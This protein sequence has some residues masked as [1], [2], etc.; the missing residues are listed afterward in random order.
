MSK[1][2]IFLSF[3]CLLTLSATAQIK[4]TTGTGSDTLRRQ[5]LDSTVLESAR[6]SGADNIATVSLDDNDMGD[7]A[8]QAVSSVLTAGRDPFFSAASFNFSALR[9][10]VRGYDA[11]MFSAYINGLPMENLDNGFSPFALW[12]G[13]NDV[14]RNRDLA[15]GL[16]T[17]TFAFGDLGSTTNIDVRASKQRKQTEI[18][19]D[20]SNRNYTH[21]LAITYGSG[22]SKKG[23]AFSFSGSRRYASEGYI[24]GSHYDGWSYFA[25]VDKR[26]GQKNLLSLVAFGAPT[27]NGRQGPS[28]QEMYDIAGTNYYNPNWGYQNGKKR[29]AAVGKSHQPVI[30]LSNETRFNNNTSWNTSVGYSFGN[31]STTAL[32]WYNSADPRPDY[33]R[34]LPSY[35]TD[36]AMQE[37][38]T[39]AMKADVNKRQ[40]N[41]D[42]LYDV[43][44]SDYTTVRN[45][46]G[47]LGND[48]SGKRSRYI[49][50]ERI[51]NTQRINANT[52][53]NTR[54]GNHV[55]FTAGASYQFQKNHYYKKVDDLLG[56]DFYVDLNQFAERD[57]HTNGDAIQ[58][59][60][61]NPNRLVKV[62]DR[63]GYNYD[64]NLHKT[65]AWAQGVFKFKKVDFFLAGEFS[66]TRFW[67]DGNV[68]NGLF[69][70]NSYGKSEENKFNNYA[71]KA[72]V[73]YKVDGRNYL[74]LNA[75]ALTRA[76]YF[77]NV[78][79]SPRTRDERQKNVTEEMVKS[80]EGGYVLNAPKLRIRISG[81]Y[82]EI[83]N[84]LNVITFY[85][86]EYQNFVNYALRNIDKVHFGTELGFEAK[87]APGLSV[88]GAAAIG[89]YYFN[90]RQLADVTVDNSSKPLASNQ[91]IYAEN[92]RV[93]STPQ[94]AYSLGLNYRSPDF[95]YVSLT[96]NYFRRAWLDFNPIRRTQEAIE[97]VE[98]GTKAWHDIVDQTELDDQF[99]LDFFGGYSYKLPRTWVNRNVFLVFN[100]GVNNILN[101]KDMITGGY[102]QLRYD[103]LLNDTEKFPPKYFYAYGI[104][105][106]LSATLRF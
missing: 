36:P 58:N 92:Y 59:D 64:I 17:N 10:K 69:P 29:N 87:V 90:S 84:Q 30:I 78:Y 13:L 96:A 46:D 22:I 86:D 67:R 53:L 51:I 26:I 98:Y 56:G 33:Y 63:H 105:F 104:N 106:F 18:E 100:A 66:N 91:I 95:W 38:I 70:N 89:R 65:A 23:W 5:R 41:W 44:Q 24:P 1:G 48:V 45:V 77:D 97:D 75:S 40:I 16:R 25:A 74:Y 76:P 11:D 49:V 83:H 55:D 47:I 102:E 32:D 81:Y 61:N 3:L 31:R 8:S 71:F 50:E 9:F 99:T 79:I 88:T 15:I 73:T 82:T 19:Y 62:G 2:S 27:E 80:V 12:G 37:E 72:G 101:N 4:E 60:L 14:T 34:Y 52:V 35:A 39:A 94:E 6:E 20:F 57:Y 85:H 103:F 68:R 21:K 7:A 43:N 42:R 93:P 54:L 28:V